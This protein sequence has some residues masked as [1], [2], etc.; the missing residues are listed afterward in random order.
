M[1]EISIQ[2]SHWWTFFMFV[3]IR[4]KKCY[5]TESFQIRFYKCIFIFIFA[6]FSYFVPFAPRHPHSPLYFMFHLLS[7]I[8]YCNLSIY[9][10]GYMVFFDWSN[11]NTFSGICHARLW[12]KSL[13]IMRLRRMLIAPL[14]N[15]WTVPMTPAGA[16]SGSFCSLGTT[17]R[18]KVCFSCSFNFAI[19]FSLRIWAVP[20]LATWTT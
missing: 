3:V 20:T 17:S 1:K 8:C 2:F 13:K 15:W 10:I 19:F 14:Q 6:F 16:W 4:R 11:H 7:F 18:S 12:I 9:M 5:W